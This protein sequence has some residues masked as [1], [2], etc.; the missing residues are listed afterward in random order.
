MTKLPFHP[1]TGGGKSAGTGVC[2][3]LFLIFLLTDGNTDVISNS[4][5]WK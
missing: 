3:F 4:L 5:W 1:V 2:L